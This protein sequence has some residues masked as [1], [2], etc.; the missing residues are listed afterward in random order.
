MSEIAVAID[1]GGTEIKGALV[2]REGGIQATMQEPTGDD[3][4]PE[5]VIQRLAS[6]ADR[7]RHVAPEGNTVIGIGMGCPGGIYPTDR[8]VSQS[9]N[10]PGWHDVDLVGPLAGLTGLPVALDNDANV[11][12]YGEFR[13]GIGRDV[14]SMVLLTLGTGIGGG[15]ILEGKIWRGTWGMAGEVGHVIVEPDGHPCGCGGWGCVEQYASGPAIVRLAREAWAAGEIPR[16]PNH[17]RLDPDQLTPALLYQAAKAGCPVSQQV[18]TTSAMYLGIL[19][20]GLLNV[21]NVPLFALGG[22]VSASFDLL[23]P[24]I[25][26]VVRRRAYRIPGENVRIERALLGNEAGVIGAGMLAFHEQSA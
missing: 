15:V 23:Y 12:A 19:I 16:L 9:P 17:A 25:R 2:D 6:V 7:L 10:F 22:G 26:E 4:S 21:L 24:T 13:C 11:A 14:D 18:F 8:R 1:L 20:T 5:A 3:L